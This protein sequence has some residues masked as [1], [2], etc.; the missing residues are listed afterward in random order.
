M[1]LF[2]WNSKVEEIHFSL[3]NSTKTPPHF[4]VRPTPEV[5]VVKQIRATFHIS[6]F[7][8]CL[9]FVSVVV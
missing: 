5:S 1:F 9:Y 6:V 2:L 8:V 7:L 4:L 3:V